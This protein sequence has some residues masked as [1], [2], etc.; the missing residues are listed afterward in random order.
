MNLIIIHI[1]ALSE[2]EKEIRRKSK[3]VQMKFLIFE[4]KF[5]ELL[6]DGEVIPAFNCLRL[7]NISNMLIQYW[8]RQEL[9]PLNINEER[10]A[11]LAQVIMIKDHSQIRTTAS[12]QGNFYFYK[13]AVKLFIQ[14]KVVLLAKRYWI[15]YNTIFLITLCYLPVVYR[16]FS[17][18]VNDSR[19]S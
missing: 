14:E 18:N 9:A 1:K 2:L 10:L 3:V 4:Q 7:A 13:Q 8:F 15:I 12:W 19:D 11:K 6:D 16:L 17:N 5:L